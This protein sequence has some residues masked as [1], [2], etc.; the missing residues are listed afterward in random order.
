MKTI[1]L[2]LISLSAICSIGTCQLPYDIMITEFMADPSPSVGLPESE[3][4]ELKN[5]S[6]HPINM[7]HW[8]ITD[9]NSK[10]FI[11]EDCIIPADSFLIVCA[12]A[13]VKAFEAFGKVA[14][15]SGF[16][17][18]DNSGDQLRLVSSDGRTIHAVEY[19]SAWINDLIKAQGGFTWEM[20]DISKPCTVQSNWNMS[21][22][23]FG[24]TPGATNSIAGI[25]SD[26][27]PPKAV[28]SYAADSVH[29]VVVF[30]KPLDSNGAVNPASYSISD[31][32]NQPLA[33]TAIAP[34][35]N[36][37]T[38]QL[39]T[40]VTSNREYLVH[41]DGIPDCYGHKAPTINGIRTGLADNNPSE[42]VINEI[43]FNP[44]AGG[45]DYVELYNAGKSIINAAALYVG[46]STNTAGTATVYKCAENPMPIFPG[47]YFVIT[48]DTAWL[49]ENYGIRNLNA[50]HSLDRLP[51]LPDENGEVVIFSG[52]GK[53]IDAFQYSEKFHFPLIANAEGVA[54]ERIDPYDKTGSEENWFSAS[55]DAGYGTPGGLNSQ[56]KRKEN[57]VGKLEVIPETFSP[58]MD[59]FNDILSI[60]YSFPQSGF[61]CSIFIFNSSGHLVKT[62]VRNQLCGTEGSY[63]WDGLNEQN[64]QLPVGIYLLAA[65]IFDLTGK[66]NKIRKAV[67]LARK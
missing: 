33:A 61:S 34:F 27:E 45:F 64:M 51:A 49:K 29:I 6:G 10:G 67:I 19:R 11:K 21:T 26:T 8:Y 63:R 52:S 57:T 48:E 16:P 4:I 7:Q 17:S 60:Q 65:E 58:D 28:Y 18:L 9:G 56:F 46:N 31:G 20:I 12:T 5:N 3:F 41:H 62:L 66:I 59:G 37:V 54:L 2:S 32:I 43:L 40:P 23:M 55:S 50:I 36:I 53:I 30:D 24:G 14:G 42:I 13:Y 15:V 38:L 22:A 39:K 25:I 1:M 47:D 44:E 35:F